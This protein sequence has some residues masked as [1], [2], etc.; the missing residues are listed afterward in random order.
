MNDIRTALDR[1]LE[2]IFSA[3]IETYRATTVADLTLYEWHV[4]PHR[5]EGIPFHEFIMQEISR[6]DTAGLALDPQPVLDAAPAEK[7]RLHYELAN[8]RQQAYGDTAIC[9]Y[10]ILIARGSRSGVRVSSYNESRVMVRLDGEWLVAHVHK[11][12]AWKAPFQPPE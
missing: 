2:S 7:E 8:Y 10:T 12:P 4:T 6:D 11:S 3:D 9:S 1:H 5:I